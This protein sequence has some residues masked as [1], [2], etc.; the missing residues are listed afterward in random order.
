MN[1]GRGRGQSLSMIVGLGRYVGGKLV[2][3]GKSNDI[4]YKPVEFDGW[5]ERHWTELFMGERFSL[6]WFTP[7]GY[8][9]GDE[10]GRSETKKSAFP[11][12]SKNDRLSE[13]SGD[14][15]IM[16][17]EE[18]RAAHLAAAAPV[19]EMVASSDKKRLSALQ[20][21]QGTTDVLVINEVLGKQTYALEGDPGWSTL[22][23]KS[24]IA[25]EYHHISFSPHGHTV[26]DAGAHIGCFTR[27]ALAQGAYAIDAFEPESSN[28]DLLCR[29]VGAASR[30]EP[31][32]VAI[33]H[34][35]APTQKRF[36]RGKDR[37]DGLVNTWRH[38]LADYSHYKDISSAEQINANEGEKYEGEEKN[39]EH[40]NSLSDSA[41]VSTM[42]FFGDMGV[43]C[44]SDR[45]YTFVKLDIE[46]A[47]VDIL[48]SPKAME[49]AS[50]CSVERV[51]FEWSFTKVPELETFRKAV[52]NL[53]SA[54][55][56]VTFEGKG[57]WWD[58]AEI[59]KWP[60][61]TDLLV[62]AARRPYIS[63]RRLCE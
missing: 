29:N 16:P 22:M 57:S 38:A 55:F 26:L 32:R 1:S 20:Y 17:S 13:Q 30:V 18:Q 59:D 44:A 53:E 37:G 7:A 61:H 4:R 23:A 47:E 35:P 40:S 9:P 45:K 2:V 8:L 41:T 51:I 43:L 11:N 27:Y 56:Y 5:R 58:S 15:N 39:Q 50:W 33:F 14:S 36:V 52:K 49:P 25:A 31:K 62:F 21:R 60:Y 46:G 34:S 54:G 10:E 48:C 24:D 3:E 19:V 63:N 42:P 28:F 12:I 6:V